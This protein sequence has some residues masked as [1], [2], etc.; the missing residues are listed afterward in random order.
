MK[1]KQG[2]GS[3]KRGENTVDA[4]YSSKAGVG[5]LGKG[6]YART[7]SGEQYKLNAA[8]TNGMIPRVGSEIDPSQHTRVIAEQHGIPTDH[9]NPQGHAYGS[10]EAI[11]DFTKQ[12]G[13]P[14]DHAAEA[15]GFNRG[16]REINRLARQ[17]K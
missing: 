9:L 13:G 1:D 5:G 17:G 16:W 6:I 2:H 14:R 11:K 7:A 3:N 10:S 15:R 8:A 12:Y 4:T